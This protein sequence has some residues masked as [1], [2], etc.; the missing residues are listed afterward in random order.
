MAGASVIVEAVFQGST[1]LPKDQYTNTF[2]FTNGTAGTAVDVSAS[3]MYQLAHFYEN[4]GDGWLSDDLGGVVTFKAYDYAAPE[5]REQINISSWDFPAPASDVALPQEVA[6]CMSFYSGRNLPSLRG[7]I[8]LGPL[9][10]SVLGPHNGIVADAIVAQA[11]GIMGELLAGDVSI[12]TPVLAPLG[13]H[14]AAP[15]A[16]CQYSR[17]DHILHPVSAGWVDNEWD[18]QRRR[19]LKATSRH[20]FP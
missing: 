17:K 20:T 12:A 9:N 2:Y 5:P 19:R 10:A 14:T 3:A 8:Y 1:G 16:W 4:S 6:L 15:A 11:A 18:T 7:R 13:D